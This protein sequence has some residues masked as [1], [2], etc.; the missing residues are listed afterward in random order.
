MV[1]DRTRQ[2]LIA[3]H[4]PGNLEWTW[5]HM[6]ERTNPLSCGCSKAPVKNPAAVYLPERLLASSGVRLEVWERRQQE[7]DIRVL[8]LLDWLRIEME[9]PLKEG[10]HCEIPSHDLSIEVHQLQRRKLR[11]RSIA[12]QSPCRHHQ[13]LRR[14]DSDQSQVR[15]QQWCA[16]LYPGRLCKAIAVQVCR[17]IQR[18]FR[19]R[20]HSC[21]SN[22]LEIFGKPS[23]SDF[24]QQ[25]RRRWIQ[26]ILLLRT[27]LVQRKQ[28]FK[29][30]LVGR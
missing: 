11:E 24:S 13:S 6:Q 28:K 29:D 7:L 27:L 9:E 5:D 23:V 25:W 10:V 2:V 30:Q 15:N 12:I 16:S 26:W 4:T 22:F 14:T 20:Q 21:V 3:V 8:H 17:N 1:G 18:D 19:S